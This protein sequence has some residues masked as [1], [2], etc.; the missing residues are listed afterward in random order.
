M[1]HNIGFILPGRHNP[2]DSL[3]TRSENVSM[4]LELWTT[5]RGAGAPAT[6][7]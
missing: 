6:E 4:A 1:R 3:T 7:Y 5:R 2:F